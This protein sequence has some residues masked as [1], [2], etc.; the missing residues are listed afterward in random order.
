MQ[1][2]SGVL[3]L[4]NDFVLAMTGYRPNFDFL[5]KLGI[6][7]RNDEFKTPVYDEETLETN[8]KGIYL[9]GVIFAFVQA[10]PGSML[11]HVVYCVTA[12][13]FSGWSKW[14]PKK[15]RIRLAILDDISIPRVIK[16]VRS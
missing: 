5:K 13:A 7:L 1:T 12:F 16:N 4:E 10:T 9:A 2:P 6:K 11:L 14:L 15:L 8:I 3:K